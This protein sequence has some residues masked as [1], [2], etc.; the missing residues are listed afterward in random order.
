M[1]KIELSQLP[2]LC[3]SRNRHSKRALIVRTLSQSSG[4]SSSI[5]SPI[6]AAVHKRAIERRG[7]SF[8]PQQK[9]TLSALG[10]LKI[11]GRYMCIA[12]ALVDSN[13]RV[14]AFTKG[15]DLLW[16]IQGQYHR[17]WRRC[18]FKDIHVYM[19]CVEQIRSA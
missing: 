7:I 6:S 3:R 13:K 16:A 14:R 18:V 1:K 2:L 8:S 4:M 17:K 5:L 9:D 11:C 19:H 15:H 12:T 10:I